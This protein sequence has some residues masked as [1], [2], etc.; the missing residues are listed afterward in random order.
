M[1]IRVLGPL[2]VEDG[3]GVLD[4]GTRKQRN[5]LTVLAL[6]R[7]RIVP[8][9]ALV[10]ALWPEGPP[11]SHAV[12]LQ[13]YVA[14]LRKALEPD[15]A[16]RAAATILV[17]SDL[18]YALR[19]P[20]G[21]VDADELDR[22]ADRLAAAFP[23]VP[24]RPWEPTREIDVETVRACADDADDALDLWRGEPYADLPDEVALAERARLN[25]TRLA[26]HELREAVRLHLGA[27]TDAARRL[28]PLALEHPHRERLWLLYAVAL[29]R[30]GRQV[31][32]LAAL[33]R[34]RT[35]LR[36]ELGVDPG[37]A[38][39]ALE[40]SILQGHLDP[41]AATRPTVVRVALVDD[42]P[43]FRMGMAGLLGSL[44]GIEVAG[45]AGDA[46][47]ARALVDD[48]VDVVLMDLD[49]GAE[50]GI[51][52]TAELLGRHPGLHVLVMTMHDDDTHV[53]AAL[54]SGAS[55]YLVKSAEPD[56]VHRALRAVARGE[57]IVGADAARAARGQLFPETS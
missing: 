8:T 5:L 57:F 23:T 21:A 14:N 53:G 47:S 56:D 29:V 20:D 26:L 11:A 49:L 25:E 32:G 36:E 24:D 42:H 50:S 39:P 28:E 38:V 46:A 19:L 9:S 27:A 22:A 34:F 37:R 54:R 45:V 41:A 52:L 6:R 40:T 4:L 12:T 33:R 35:T 7:G 30:A 18:G 55:G 1:R 13:G 16:P 51:D 15:R 2:E 31:E 44:D 17:T 3:T 10:D 48:T 43:V